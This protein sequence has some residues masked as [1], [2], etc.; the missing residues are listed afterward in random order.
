MCWNSSTQKTETCSALLPLC[1]CDCACHTCAPVPHSTMV[2]SLSDR[3]FLAYAPSPFSPFLLH[4]PQKVLTYGKMGLI[5]DVRGCRWCHPEIYVGQ[6]RQ[7]LPTKMSALFTKRKV[8]QNSQDA[9][10]GSSL[11]CRSLS[12]LVSLWALKTVDG[13]TQSYGSLSGELIPC[14]N[15]TQK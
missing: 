7:N 13:C 1:V 9:G 12:A 4:L 5:G 14:K 15:L 11:G 6:G 8:A 10:V 3:V 2:P